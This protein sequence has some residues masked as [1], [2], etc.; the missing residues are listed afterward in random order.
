MPTRKSN[1]TVILN[2]ALD[3]R[4]EDT[5]FL[6]Q[7]RRYKK[8]GR[9]RNTEVIDLVEISQHF[10]DQSKKVKKTVRRTIKHTKNT[11][12][13]AN[14]VIIMGHCKEMS[15]ELCSDTGVITTTQTI[16]KLLP[17]DISRK[18]IDII[19]CQGDR[20]TQK[21][22]TDM[23]HKATPD[24][25]NFNCDGTIISCR[26][27]ILMPLPTGQLIYYRKDNRGL[28]HIFRRCTN[29][30]TNYLLQSNGVSVF[31]ISGKK[32]KSKFENVVS[33]YHHHQI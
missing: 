18:H 14:K 16:L 26:N 2:F 32:D 29:Y 28:P 27:H 30:R 8:F 24:N 21:L 17:K 6:N 3:N 9:F 12:A 13:A 10:N 5:S 4:Q 11:I 1:D 20:F 31:A 7:Y 19:A 25:N 22:I 15:A 23:Q 33:K